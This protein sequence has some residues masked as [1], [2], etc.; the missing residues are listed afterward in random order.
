MTK[1]GAAQLWDG[2]GAALATLGKP[3]ESVRSARFSPDSSRIGRAFVDLGPGPQPAQ[4]EGGA[5]LT[6]P[7]RGAPFGFAIVLEARLGRFDLGPLGIRGTIR[8]DPLSGRVTV[9]S[10]SA[11]R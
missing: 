7:Y 6:G 3:G 2:G 5:Y 8:L 10:T 1:S 11:V 4:L 9:K